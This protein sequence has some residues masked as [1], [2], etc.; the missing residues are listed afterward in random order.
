MKKTINI[1]VLVFLVG[2]LAASPAAHAASLL[3]VYQQALQSDPQI[4]EAE[5]RRL[6]AQVDA[7]RAKKVLK[8]ADFKST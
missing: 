6:A 2:L 5:A 3:E 4:H 8:P 1:S 7:A